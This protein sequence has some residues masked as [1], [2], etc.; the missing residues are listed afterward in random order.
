MNGLEL[1][2]SLFEKIDQAKHV[3]SVSDPNWQGEPTKCH[4][5]VERW[6]ASHPADRPVRGYLV[7]SPNEYGAL[8]D[9]HS[10]VLRQDGSLIDVTPLDYRCPFIMYDMSDAMFRECR[11]SLSQIPYCTIDEF[12]MMPVNDN[13]HQF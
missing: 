6:I 1:A 5:N 11:K 2:K 7:T 12:L 13:G 3:E 9:L 8:F 10:V 4:Q